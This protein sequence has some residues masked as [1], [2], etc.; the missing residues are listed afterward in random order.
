MNNLPSCWQVQNDGSQLFKDTVVK[1]LN[2]KISILADRIYSENVIKGW[3]YGY[4]DGVFVYDT[5]N[6]QFPFEVKTLTLQEF[7][8][9]TTNTKLPTKWCISRTPDTAKAIN[10]WFNNKYYHRSKNTPF[11][12]VDDTWFNGTRRYLHCETVD[13]RWLYNYVIEGYTEINFEQF[14]QIINMR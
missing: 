11:S 14:K 13:N 9:L 4:N 1:Y 7:I 3:Y 6:S 12:A 10:D 5:S 8:Y 2:S